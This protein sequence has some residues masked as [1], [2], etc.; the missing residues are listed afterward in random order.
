MILAPRN[1]DFKIFYFKIYTA[2]IFIGPE[3]D[4]WLCLSLTNSLTDSLTDCRLVNLMPVN[5]AAYAVYN[6]QRPSNFHYITYYISVKLAV[7]TSETEAPCFDMI[8]ISLPTPVTNFPSFWGASQYF[9]FSCFP[10]LPQ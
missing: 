7:K 8:L 6:W 2:D 9:I 1:G 10:P 5:D 4:H 3:S